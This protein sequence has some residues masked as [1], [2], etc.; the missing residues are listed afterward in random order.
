MAIVSIR[1]AKNKLAELGHRA[2]SG[3]R[4]IVTRHGKPAFELVPPQKKGGLNLEAGAEYLRSIGIEPR[5]S[6]IS[7]DFD[8][9]L[10]EDFLLQPLPEPAPRKLG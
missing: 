3:E 9:P 7:P 2:E 6:W 4:I 8:A 10:P 1:E 5:G